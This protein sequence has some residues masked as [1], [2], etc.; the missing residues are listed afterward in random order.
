MLEISR[1]NGRYECY[2]LAFSV[3]I[4]LA[5]FSGSATQFGILSEPKVTR[6]KLSTTIKSSS[7]N[8]VPAIFKTQVRSDKPAVQAESPQTAKHTD[9]T[10]ILAARVLSGYSNTEFL[11][12]DSVTEASEPLEDWNLPIDSLISKSIKRLSV[13][14]FIL[15]TGKISLVQLL[16]I[17]PPTTDLTFLQSIVDTIITTPMKAAKL[18]GEFVSSERKIE[19]VLSKE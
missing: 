8:T 13:R 4:H 1:G 10:L 2:F 9:S 16:E 3:V 12:I 14:L 6:A 18:N 7:S 5:L 19:L 11:S 17:E 15:D